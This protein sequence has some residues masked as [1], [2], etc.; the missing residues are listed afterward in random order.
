MSC[1]IFPIF[2]VPFIFPGPWRLRQEKSSRAGRFEGASL[3]GPGKAAV[4]LGGPQLELRRAWQPTWTA[5]F[6]RGGPGAPPSLPQT[7]GRVTHP[8][9]LPPAPLT[10]RFGAEEYS[11]VGGGGQACAWGRA[12]A[13]KP[14]V[15]WEARR[16]G[17]VASRRLAVGL[18]GGGGVRRESLY[19]AGVGS[20]EMNRRSF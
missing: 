11:Q 3:R 2:L 18:P 12:R 14:E 6:W 9:V 16:E 8:H 13:R 10:R 19:P 4:P 7:A 5:E 1:V 17:V 20:K 15:G